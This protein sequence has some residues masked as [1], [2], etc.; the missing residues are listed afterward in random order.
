MTAVELTFK[1]REASK[2]A[3]TRTQRYGPR[4]VIPSLIL[5][6]TSL[7]SVRNPLMEK[8]LLNFE[9]MLL[10]SSIYSY[11]LTTKIV[12]LLKFANCYKRDLNEYGSQDTA[13]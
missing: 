5:L 7:L 1:P 2:M 3:K 10:F 13:C 9:R 11:A 4:K 12:F 6:T 8:Y